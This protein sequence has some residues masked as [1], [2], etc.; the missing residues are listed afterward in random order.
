[1]ENVLVS[2]GPEPT[3]SDADF[4][5]LRDAVLGRQAK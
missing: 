4:A 5:V 3:L 1:L 2:R